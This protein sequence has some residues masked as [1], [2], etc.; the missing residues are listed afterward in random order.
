MV[1]L[2]GVNLKV[3]GKGFFN[4]SEYC[5]FLSVEVA[6][7]WGK[8]H[9]GDW[10]ENYKTECDTTVLCNYCGFR[11]IHI[12]KYLRDENKTWP[13][14]TTA[15]EN[16]I[17]TL[18]TTIN[19]APRVPENIIVYRVVAKSIIEKIIEAS[20][21]YCK[22]NE[23]FCEK[24]FLSTSLIS[25]PALD[26]RDRNGDNCL[27]R[28][29]IQKDT[30]GAYVYLIVGSRREEQEMLFLPDCYLRLINRKWWRSLFCSKKIGKYQVYDC[31]L[32]YRKD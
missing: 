24:G 10:S 6:E 18:K 20:E 13:Y 19:E 2:T 4:G 21:S 32:S 23:W 17:E 22:T 30:Q 3:A 16:E 9:Y 8:T 28:I 7:A 27:L 1:F 15:I 11:Y 5:E 12:N 14:D 26:I 29:Y 25:E 31:E